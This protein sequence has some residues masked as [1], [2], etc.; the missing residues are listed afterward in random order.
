KE[1]MVLI[2]TNYRNIVLVTHQFDAAIK[3]MIFEN[4]LP[5]PER[6][7]YRICGVGKDLKYRSTSAPLPPCTCLQQAGLRQTRRLQN[8]GCI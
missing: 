8:L 6:R 4:S 1:F 5:L 7:F 3:V 2:S